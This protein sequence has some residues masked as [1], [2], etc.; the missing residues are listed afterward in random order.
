MSCYSLKDQLNLNPMFNEDD[1]VY[2][3]E[4]LKILVQKLRNEWKARRLTFLPIETTSLNMNSNQIQ[5]WPLS[6]TID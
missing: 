6:I 2:T 3:M 5:S 1:K 4:D